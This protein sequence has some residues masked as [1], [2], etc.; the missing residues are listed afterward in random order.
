MAENQN[1][2]FRP[3]RINFAQISNTALWDDNLS[4]KAKGLYSL[5]QSLITIPGMDLRIWKIKTK[6]KEKDKAF[7]SSWIELK[8]NGYLKQYRIPSGAKGAFKYE[9]DLLFE[10]DLKTASVINLDKDGNIASPKGTSQ[11]KDCV[12]EPNSD[13]GPSPDLTDC[14]HTPH[15]GGSGQKAEVNPDHSPQNG[16]GGQTAE[17]GP[18]HTP[19]FPPYAKCTPCLN[20]PVQ[21]EGDNSNTQSGNTFSGNTPVGNTLS[22][23]LPPE[24][25][26]R[27]TD[28]TRSKILDQ[29]EY[30]WIEET[31]PNDTQAVKAIVDYM[32]DMETLPF[33][34]ISRVKQSRYALRKRLDTVSAEDVINFIDHM[35]GVKPKNIRNI[36]AY[37]KSAF[38]NY[39]GEQ[40]LALSTV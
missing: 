20:H 11:E 7:E 19:H 14:D 29:I 28:E 34:K 21:K 39:L 18:D 12:Q 35:R 17:N 1:A 37:W 25:T 4:L 8:K 30:D 22:V 3:K 36:N 5:I 6:C 33:T 38:I 27:S 13:S 10:P 24:E 31:H 32:V 16:G 15:N 23:S 40:D 26:D 9:Y 2:S